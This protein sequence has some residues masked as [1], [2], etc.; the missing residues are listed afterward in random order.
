MA[1]G[2]DFF[3]GWS[4]APEWMRRRAKPK[5]YKGSKAAKRAAR[6]HRR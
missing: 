4:R 1:T 5:A 6:I 2:I 3:A